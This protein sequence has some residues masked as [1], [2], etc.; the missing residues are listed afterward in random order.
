MRLLGDL[1][2]LS[3]LHSDIGTDMWQLLPFSR[4]NVTITVHILDVQL[5]L[6]SYYPFADHQ[7]LYQ[8][9]SLRELFQR[10]LRFSRPG[11]WCQIDEADI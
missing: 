2:S 10:S 11:G 5:L 3:S 7:P 6:N 8:T 1:N 9:K 4:G